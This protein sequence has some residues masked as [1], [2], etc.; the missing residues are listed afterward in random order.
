[1]ATSGNSN[2]PNILL[3]DDDEIFGKVMVAMA[4]DKGLSLTYV[5][6]VR[7]AYHLSEREFDIAIVDYDLGIVNGIQL[8]S[9]FEKHL[10]PQMVIL[11][12]AHSGIEKKDW[13]AL[14]K[15]FLPKGNGAASILKEAVALFHPKQGG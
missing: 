14:I 5:Q 1:M 12:S 3:V 4:R 2:K 10:K 8:A 6:S 9:F 15:G 11:T 7:D 13:P